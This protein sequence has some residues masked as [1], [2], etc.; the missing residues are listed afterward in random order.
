MLM[1]IIFRSYSF[2][3]S[4]SKSTE[5][6]FS[7]VFGTAEDDPAPECVPDVETIPAFNKLL[8]K[9]AILADGAP[10]A[11]D[12]NMGAGVDCGGGSKGNGL[13]VC[14]GPDCE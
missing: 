10:I 8:N 5:L 13:G 12:V 1:L 7:T 2:A 4:R 6:V 14:D 9:S 11:S 3:V